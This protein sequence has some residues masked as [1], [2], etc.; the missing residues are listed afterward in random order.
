M[1]NSEAIKAL[2][3]NGGKPAVEGWPYKARHHFGAE[4]KAACDRV[5]QAAID[6]GD[7]PAYGGAEEEAFCKEFAELMGGGYADAVSSGTDSVFVALRSVGIEPFTEVICGPVTD[8]GGMMPIVMMNCI[9]V[10]AD[11]EPGSFNI[12]LESIKKRYTKNTSAI[13]VAH[14]AGEPADMEGIMAFAKEKGLKVVEDCAQAH[15]ATINGK[16]VGTFGDAA[17]YSL[18]YGK[19]TCV[20][21]QGGIVFTKDEETY[22]RIRQNSDRGKPFGA[23]FFGYTPDTQ[24]VLATLNFNL[25]EMHC[26][27][28]RV[29][30]QKMMDIAERRR[31]VVAK[32]MAGLEARG[33]DCLSISKLHE[34]AVPSYWFLR[35]LYDESKM[36]VD[37]NT[38]C[39]AVNKEGLGTNSYYQAT[40]W[41]YD[42]Y[43]NRAVFGK[44]GYPW[45][46]PE[47]KGD[48]DKVW[49]EADLPNCMKALN[50]TIIIFPN[51]SWD[52]ASIDAA[53]SAFA[54]VYDA[55]K[56]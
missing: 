10:V 20:G 9:P 53:V 4:E 34:G 48:K 54:K 27:I 22:W 8:A 6:A 11:S 32:I 15:G 55:Y 52:D 1:A 33:V 49:G 47:Y 43:R 51:E 42:W 39:Q 41:H 30:I 7:A 14:I 5:L 26:A 44:S 46:A 18:M 21:G 25:D 37:K 31:A 35:L 56:K 19:H 29:Q 50:D 23:E 24:N 40:P 38:F 45:A 12:S 3:I 17:G 28:G 13:L 2:A 36:T 16:K